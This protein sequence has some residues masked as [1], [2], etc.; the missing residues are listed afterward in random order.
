MPVST[1]GIDEIIKDSVKLW[2]FTAQMITK[3]LLDILETQKLLKISRNMLQFSL[4]I[5]ILLWMLTKSVKTW[6]K[7]IKLSNSRRK[8]LIS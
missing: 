8:P 7:Q 2:S 5:L 6:K 3:T 1:I 4:R